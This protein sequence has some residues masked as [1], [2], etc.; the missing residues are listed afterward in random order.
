MIILILLFMFFI[1]NGQV[2]SDYNGGRS[3][4]DFLQFLT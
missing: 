1:R 2:S 3:E 4:Q